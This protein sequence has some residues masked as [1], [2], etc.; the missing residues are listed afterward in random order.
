MKESVNLG[1]I[2]GQ[3]VRRLRQKKN[4]TQEKLAEKSGVCV[5]TIRNIEKGRWPSA[6]TLQAVAT[7]LKVDAKFLLSSE[8][9][10]MYLKEELKSKL[11]QAFDFLVKKPAETDGKAAYSVGHLTGLKKY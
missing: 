4:I 2:V 1:F 10:E 9:D 3:N 11:E 8:K 5:N 7:A 6:Y